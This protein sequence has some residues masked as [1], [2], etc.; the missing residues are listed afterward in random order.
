MTDVILRQVPSH[1]QNNPV[2][3][4]DQLPHKPSCMLVVRSEASHERFVEGVGANGNLH[5]ILDLPNLACLP[6]LRSRAT[7]RRS[8][9]HCAG[10]CGS[11]MG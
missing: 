1:F 7:G 2:P 5:D 6:S 3:I 9:W 4:R 11:T 10:N 8:L